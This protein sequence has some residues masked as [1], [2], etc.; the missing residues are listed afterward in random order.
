MLCLLG[1][2]RDGAHARRCRCIQV[3]LRGLVG[4]AGDRAAR[5]IEILGRRGGLD[6]LA[7]AAYQ[8]GDVEVETA[9]ALIGV[10]VRAVRAGFCCRSDLLRRR[11]ARHFFGRLRAAA[12]QL[13][14]RAGHC[15]RAV[16][17]HFDGIDQLFL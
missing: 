13:L 11:A 8:A 3:C 15:D 4:H 5:E 1:G 7:D 6:V 16:G 2:G 17:S 9:L 12:A 10:R 14:E